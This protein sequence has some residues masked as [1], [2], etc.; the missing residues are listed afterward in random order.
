MGNSSKTESREEGNRE[1]YDCS[2]K[3]ITQTIMI[4]FPINCPN[5]LFSL[6]NRTI[7]HALVRNNQQSLSERWIIDWQSIT[8]PSQM[9]AI[10]YQSIAIDY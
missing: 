7:V 9:L 3:S 8:G 1:R 6:N 10:D 4:I 5:Q 2:K